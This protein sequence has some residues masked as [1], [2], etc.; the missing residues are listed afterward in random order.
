MNIQSIILCLQDYWAKQNCLI[1]N[2]YDEHVGAGTMSPN[3][4]L[5]TLGEKPWNTA[6]VQPSRRPKDGRYGDNPN[7]LYQHHQM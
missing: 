1:L 7:R 4:F 2:P 5:K 3:T 6:Y